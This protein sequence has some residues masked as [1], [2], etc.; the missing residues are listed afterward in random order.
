[1]Y[2]LGL[3]RS[4]LSVL[5]LGISLQY[6]EYLHGLL[7][8]RLG[9]KGLAPCDSLESIEHES[10]TA[11]YLYGLFLFCF[12][13]CVFAIV[14]KCVCVL[15]VCVRACVRVCVRACVCVLS[16]LLRTFNWT[17]FVVPVMC[18]V[19]MCSPVHTWVQVI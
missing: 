17:K 8:V 1:M 10:S 6:V 18:Q 5:G 7:T 19:Y 13:V 3:W 14:F 16:I 4:V 15:C 9:V 12:S 11:W 2:V